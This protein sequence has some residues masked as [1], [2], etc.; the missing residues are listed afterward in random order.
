MRLLPPG[1]CLTKLGKTAPLKIPPELCEGRFRAGR[2]HLFQRDLVA[3]GDQ[4]LYSPSRWMFSVSAVKKVCSPIFE[5]KTVFDQVVSD[6]DHGMGYGEQSAFR[7]S[8]RLEP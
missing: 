4:P 1:G 2:P 8:A 5:L 7:T 3:Q 6:D